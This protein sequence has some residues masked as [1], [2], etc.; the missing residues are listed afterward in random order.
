[1]PAEV[2]SKKPHAGA[3]KATSFFPCHQDGC[4]KV[5]RRLSFLKKTTIIRTM[6]TVSRKTDFVR[7]CQTATIVDWRMVWS[8]YLS[9][10]QFHCKWDCNR[11]GHFRRLGS[12]K[13]TKSPIILTND[14][15]LV[16]YWSNQSQKV[17]WK[18][19]CKWYEMFLRLTEFAFLESL[20]SWHQI[21]YCATSHVLLLKSA[22]IPPIMLISR[23]VKRTILFEGVLF[24][25]WWNSCGVTFW[26]YRS[27]CKHV[28]WLSLLQ[29]TP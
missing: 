12:I 20:S 24:L 1:M 6:H 21:N 16:F 28:H 2:L 23:P 17:S 9:P 19:S 7:P 11:P 26:V 10:L 22:N 13:C 14:R 18:F 8:G 5:F 25:L 29:D 15:S 3:E 4:I 27:V